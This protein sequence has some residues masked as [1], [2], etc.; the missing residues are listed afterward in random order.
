VSSPFEVARHWWR[1]YR[2][3]PFLR[4]FRIFSERIFRGG[5]DS[6]ADGLDLG[7]GLV[8]TL[9]ALPGGFVSVLMFVKYSTFLSWM[10]GSP[11]VD[12][13]IVAMPDE[14]FF[15]T[16]SMAVTGAV[17]VW[18]WDTLFPDLRDYTNM[19]PLPISTS[20]LFSANLAAVLFLA[21]LIA[22]DV[23]A[24]SSVL[25]PLGVAATQRSF[26]FFV[27]FVGVHALVVGVAS[28][29]AFFAVLTL[30]GFFLVI[31][32]PRVFRK[33]SPYVRALVVMY[34]V[35]LLST[36]FALPDFLHSLPGSSID[37]TALLP[38]C[39]F[40][41]LC[42]TLRGR[43]DPALSSLARI[44]LPGLGLTIA[45]A[46]CVYALGYR[47]H[48]LRIPEMSENGAN[49]RHS[50]ATWLRKVFD[51]WILRT[52]FQRGCFHFVCR[53][54]F[55]SEPHRLAMAGIS[56][57]GIVLASQLL[58][59]AVQTHS[60][61]N[62]TPSSNALAV[63][64]VLAFFIVIGL[65]IVF[66]IPVEL[67]SNWMFRITLDPEKHECQSLGKNVILTFVMPVVLVSLPVYVYVDGA[68]VGTMHTLLVGLWSLLLTNAVLVRFRK[69]PFT[70]P[71]PVFQQNS[72]VVLL[73]WVLA[74]F[75]FA[76][77]TPELESWALEEPLQMLVLLV[78]AALFWYIPRY[79]DRGAIDVEKTL[80]FDSNSARD[81]EV[82]QLGA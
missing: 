66:E 9:L 50:N 81:I 32:P 4:L 55:R 15:I 28:V 74:F 49:P 17:T 56:G 23:N 63:P 73:G 78:P 68:M 7:I 18:R 36:S 25:F 72:I 26:L 52:P 35:T 5:G 58:A 37:W 47:R 30:L 76:V 3:R 77:V 69:L 12:P 6:D 59:S 10:R 11:H 79:I 45:A 40:L 65:R 67:R 34:F 51:G 42:Q 57:L 62:A 82:L 1:F 19:V 54:L 8:L 20:L 2:E 38:S 80:T 33:I 21:G 64:F 70:C 24:A 44:A 61:R 16:L 46:F 71:L 27:K 60:A 13:L 48:F 22:F 43:A 29:F 14:Y 53:T 41:G 39:W 31:L 75:L